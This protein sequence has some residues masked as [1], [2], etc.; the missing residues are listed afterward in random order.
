MGLGAIIGAVA[1]VIGSVA[2]IVSQVNAASK[3]AESQARAAQQAA[4]LGE[5]NIELIR[6]ETG[7]SMRRLSAQQE[8]QE[9]QARAMAA[10]SGAKLEGSPLTF[11][12][13]MEE[14]N[15][16]EL[17][18]VKR[19]GLSK[20]EIEKL[21]TQYQVSNI[22]SAPLPSVNWGGFLTN[23]GGAVGQGWNAWQTYQGKT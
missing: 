21:R 12:T 19:A 13:E 3:A 20:E 11:L 15:Q 5:K 4:E 23:V 14:E 10:A 7:E 22:K 18:W 17:D 9:S 16:A 1:S 6:A 2:S 8:R